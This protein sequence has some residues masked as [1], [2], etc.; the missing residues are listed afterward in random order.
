MRGMGLGAVPARELSCRGSRAGCIGENGG[1][2]ARLALQCRFFRSLTATS[3]VMLRL[4]PTP[5]ETGN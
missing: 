1:Q 4:G 5:R 2:A 3:S